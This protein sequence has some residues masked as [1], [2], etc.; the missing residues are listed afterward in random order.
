MEAM[1]KQLLLKQK[2]YFIYSGDHSAVPSKT[3]SGK[4]ESKWGNGP[5]MRHD[6]TY[7]PSSYNMNN[8]K[9]YKKAI[10]FIVPTSVCRN[11][12]FTVTL[13]YIPAGS[14]VTWTCSSNLTKVS[15]SGAQ[16]VFRAS[17]DVY[18]YVT[19]TISGSISKTL[20][21]IIS[22]DKPN[23]SN[24]SFDVW[25]NTTGTYLGNTATSSIGMCPNTKYHIK[26]KNTSS[27]SLSNYSWSVPSGWTVYYTENTGLISI[28][29]N[30]VSGGRVVL[31]ATTGCGVTKEILAG[32]FS[33]SSNCS[34]SRSFSLYPNPAESTVTVDLTDDADDAELI[35]AERQPETLSED[36]EIQIW[37]ETGMLKSVRTTDCKVEISISDLPQGFYYVR[38]IRGGTTCSQ[39]LIVK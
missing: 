2:K 14:T 27:C 19:A 21:A 25:N 24:V 6:P 29:T 38:V 34:S 32:Y 20:T 7:G 15:S 10:S 5:L 26:I 12:N 36:A 33:G 8:R 4:Y 18:T 13:N 30:S 3:V 9:Y 16:A 1:P 11:Q 22:I 37:S 39:T 31:T 17:S 23:A 28:N 35:F